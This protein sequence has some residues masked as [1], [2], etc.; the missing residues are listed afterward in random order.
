MGRKIGFLGL[1]KLGRP[2]ACAIASRGF[3]VLGYDIDPRNMSRDSFPHRE[4]GLG[5]VSF[6]DMLRSCA[7]LTFTAHKSELVGECDLI[8]VAV[9][10]PHG[11]EYEGV[12]PMPEARQDFDYM[13]LRVAVRELNAGLRR[14]SRKA[15]PFR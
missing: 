7:N 11:P 2:V 14:K 10:T 1:G 13:A 4:E 3:D 5:T 15:S 6:P 12:T 9:Q 8:F